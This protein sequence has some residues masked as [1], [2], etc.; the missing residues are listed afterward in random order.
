M[1]RILIIFLAV[2]TLISCTTTQ[3]IERTEHIEHSE[4]TEHAERFE[5]DVEI[6]VQ[7]DSVFVDRRDS[8]FIRERGDTVVIERFTNITK[9]VD[10]WRTD[11]IFIERIDSTHVDQTQSTETTSDIHEIVERRRRGAFFQMLGIFAIGLVLGYLG[12]LFKP[13]KT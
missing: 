10:R 6:R 13:N 11:S 5:R 3:R 7:R 8:V 2:F 9:Y 12:C 4:R 1:Y